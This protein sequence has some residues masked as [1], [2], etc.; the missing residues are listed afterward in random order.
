LRRPRVF[1]ACRDISLI[2]RLHDAFG[3]EDRF[4]VCGEAIYGAEPFG[5]AIRLHPD[6]VILELESSPREGFQA[7]KALK[8]ARP[9]LPIFLITNQYGVQEEKE[10]LSS[11]IE[12]VFEMDF[13]CKS[14]MMNAYAVCG[15]MSS[16]S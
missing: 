4:E 16:E 2:R 7:A 3:R 5:E 11:G 1:I 8:E 6:L 12:A 14:I 10:A 15:L 13:D 9:D